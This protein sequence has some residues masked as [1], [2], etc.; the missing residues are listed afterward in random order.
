MSDLAIKSNNSGSECFEN[1]VASPAPVT[2]FLDQPRFEAGISRM[3]EPVTADMLDCAILHVSVEASAS[4][5]YLL[6]HTEA[7]ATML[8][9]I[10]RQ[11][12]FRLRSGALVYLGNARFAVMLWGADAQDA[13]AYSRATL[14]AIE[15]I[16]LPWEDKGLSVSAYIGGVMARGLGDG[17]ALL[18]MARAAGC[19][20]RD[21]E[22]VRVHMYREQ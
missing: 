4:T 19:V 6:G 14:S 16:S 22:G 13:L 7:G 11:L 15:E 21:K 9:R 5:S 20:A 8:N 17:V 1:R 2:V 12:R 10:G 3:L 18:S